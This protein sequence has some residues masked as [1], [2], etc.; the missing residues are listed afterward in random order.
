MPARLQ[1]IA[2]TG[3]PNFLDLPWD[4]PLE[5]WASERL[6]EVVRGIHRHVVRFVE[7]ENPM[8]PAI[9]AVKE[10]PEPIA[11]REYGLLRRL[12]AT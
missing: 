8:A 9:Y 2:R 5:A 11:R 4:E 6:V 1:L 3:H 12:A 7:Y 10:L